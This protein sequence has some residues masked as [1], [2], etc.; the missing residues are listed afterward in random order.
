MNDSIVSKKNHSGF[1][2]FFAVVISVFLWDIITMRS[3]FIGGDNLV[4]FYP[5]FKTYAESIKSFRFPFWC[6]Y[7][8]SGFPLM[9]EGQVGGYYPLNLLFF[10]IFPFKFAYN[11]SAVFHF[12]LGG[13]SIYFLTRRLGACQWGGALSALI[14][15]FGS[16]Y[17]GCFY[18]IITLRTLSWTPLVFLI[19][20]HYFQKKKFIYIFLAGLIFGFQ[21]L[22]GFT[23]MAVYSGFFYTLYYIYSLK[24]LKSRAGRELFYLLVFFVIA[25][26]IFLPQLILTARLVLYSSRTRA[27][28]EFALW[29]SFNPL[30]LVGAVFPFWAGFTRSNFYLSIL[31]I[32]FLISSFYLLKS[33]KKLRP[34]FLV[35]VVSFLLA[36]GRYN[37]IY[38]AIL[39]LT[40]LYTFRNPSKFMFFAALASSVLIGRGL[41]EFFRTEFRF[42]EKTLKAYSVVLLLCALV[43]LISKMVLHLFKDQLLAIGS[44]YA[45]K[46]I[47]GRLYHRYDLSTYFQKVS[48]FY[49]LLVRGA[50]LTSI[51]NIA[52]WAFLSTALAASLFILKRKRLSGFSG[53]KSLVLSLIFVDLFIFSF[54]G[55][56]F[57][58]N[59]YGF[60]RLRP[61]YALIFDWIK[62]DK[63][64][65]RVLPYNMAS[66]KLP[67]WIMPNA[68]MVYGIDSVA[69]YTPLASEYYREATKS[70]EIIDD[71]LGAVSPGSDSLDENQQLL[72]LLNVKYIVSPERLNKPFLSLVVSEKGVNLYRFKNYLPRAF[73]LKEL[74]MKRINL[75]AKTEILEYRE[76]QALFKVNMP[77]KGFLA[78]SENNYPG[79]KVYVDGKKEKILSFSLIQAVELDKGEH[80]VKFVYNPYY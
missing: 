67:A 77:Y 32:L 70:L 75:W 31:G 6:R 63:T 10:L 52:S 14:F 1:F 73:V 59:I 29:G 40:G 74:N 69:G 4:Q 35:L 13:V 42:R 56:G 65:F 72:E 80:T 76:G 24:L 68:N 7:M 19:F 25:G 17:A 57:R 20:E 28:L 49:S 5:W 43:F 54:I 71:S 11:Y 16:A 45:E 8:Q 64:L 46:A 33:E 61:D 53:M 30:G 9:A 51:F 39:R 36:L 18:N 48:S 58:G 23:Q 12:I 66:G 22:A 62:K 21:L 3:L 2:I 78:F 47:Y 55:T 37:P 26:I 38:A 44:W 41:S 50:S 60:E 27:N 34:L 79:W 15:C